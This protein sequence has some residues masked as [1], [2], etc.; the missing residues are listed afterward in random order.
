MSPCDDIM[1]RKKHSLYIR[2]SGTPMLRKLHKG[3][4]S[5]NAE[6]DVKTY[7]ACQNIVR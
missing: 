2:L 5:L 7:P 1:Q 3:D 6:T 4:G